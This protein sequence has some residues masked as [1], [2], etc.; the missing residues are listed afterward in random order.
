[1]TL[2]ERAKRLVLERHAHL[3][4]ISQSRQPMIE[5]IEEV[6]AMVAG[7]T[8]DAEIVAAAWLHDTVEDTDTTLDELHQLFGQRV[9]E[10]VDGLTDPP[11]FAAMPTPERKA[12]QA[13]RILSKGYEVKIIKLCDQISN[14]LSV[15]NDTPTDW[16]HAQQ[17][18]YIE[19]AANVALLCKGYSEGL[20]QKFGNAYLYAKEHYKGKL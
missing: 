15:T 17:W 1:M 12:A 10:I 18:A 19:G 8:A 11:R 7:A 5:H 16:N 3:R 14:I 2:V 4:R 20:D 9:A 6:A 13:A